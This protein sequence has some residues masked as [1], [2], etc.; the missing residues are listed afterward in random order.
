MPH[1]EIEN[2]T[3]FVLE[4]LF[5][6]DEELRPLVV[7]IVK[8]TFAIGPDRRC[9]PAEAQIPLSSGGEH[10]GDSP[11]ASSLKYEP[12]VAFTKPATD[13]VM[14]GHAYAERGDTRQTQVSLRVGPV[15]K[16]V[17]VHGDRVWFKSGGTI[18]ASRALP[19]EKIPLIYERAFG[20]WDRTHPDRLRHT[21]EPRNPVGTGYRG[22]GNFVDGTRLPNIED[23]RA[24]IKTLADKPAP[25]GF[26]FVAPEWQPRAA[27][28][29]TF[30]EAWKKSRS[31]LLPKDFSRRHLNAASAGLVAPG[32][33][34]GDEPVTAIGISPAGPLS[35]TLPGVSPPT[36]TIT[37]AAG[38]PQTVPLNLDTVIIEPDDRRVMLLWRGHLPLTRGPHDVRAVVVAS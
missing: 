34:R 5:L 21:C 1:P 25:A 30:D 2:K 27:L 29:G 18:S 24:P 13:V 3:P 23:P 33:L 9:T 11:E 8:A 20:G 36:A 17:A 26:G 16:D 14:I 35:F 22:A 10:W 32:Y 19:F 31:P 4:T 28:A 12:E 15:A 37:M 6:V 7:P 38:A